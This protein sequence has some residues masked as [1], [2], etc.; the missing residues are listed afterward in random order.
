[1]LGLFYINLVLPSILW[2]AGSNQHYYYKR[3]DGF[4]LDAAIKSDIAGKTPM[5]F[6]PIATGNEQPEIPQT[7]DTGGPGQSEMS[8]FSS[9]NASNMVDLF[10]GDFSYNIPL[11]DVGGYPVNIHYSSGI[12]MDQEASWVGLGWNVNPGTIGRS[13]RG[14][15]DDFNGTDTIT[16]TQ[17]IKE[18][19]TV[20]AKLSAGLELWGL[21]MNVGANFG[22]FH[23]NYQGWG[24][25][26]GINASISAGGKSTGALTGSL[27]L[28]NNSQTGL[29]ISPSLAIRLGGNDAA[30]NGT[31]TVGSNYNSRAGI[32][33][34]QLH[35][36]VRNNI[37]ARAIVEGVVTANGMRVPASVVRQG[38]VSTSAGIAS[39]ISFARPSYLP[40]ITMP[41][42]N[43]SFTFRAQV[44]GELWGV[45]V[46]AAL[47]G[48]GSRQFIR[49]EDRI[50]KLPAYGY[51][52]FS[53]A[54]EQN[55][56]LD[57]NREK[58]IPF[59][60]KTTPHIAIPQ[61]NYDI[62]S[63][64]GEGTGGMFRPYRGDI[65]FIHDHAVSTRTEKINIAT[66][67][68]FGGGVHLGTDFT[69]VNASTT[70]GAW[71]QD[72]ELLKN[73]PF[74]QK[75]STF[76]EVYFRNPGEKAINSSAFYSRLGGDSLIRV[77][78]GG[79]GAGVK[80]LS[81]FTKF[82]QAKPAGDISISSPILKTQRDKRRQVIT[83][84][85][86]DEATRYGLE[87]NIKSYDT[88]RNPVTGCDTAYRIIPRTDAVI[89]KSHHL[90]EMKVLNGDGRIY[91]YGLPV[92]NVEQQDL[93][94]AVNKE[95]NTD[96]LNRGMVSYETGD[97]STTNDKGKDS[98]FNS[99]RTPAYAHSFLLTG[100]LSPDY[101]DIKGDGITDDDLGD[102]VKFN[103][104]QVYGAH[105]GY[106]GWRT[107]VDSGKA[108]YNEGLKTYSRD[109]KGTY[110]YGKKELWYLHSVESK[111]MIALFKTS[112]RTDGY[113]V[114]G[115]SGGFDLTKPLKRLDSIELYTK[116]DLAKNGNNALPVKTVHF[117][118][119]YELCANATGAGTSG[120]LTLKKIWFTYNGNNKGKLNP[121][122]FYYH[123][124]A[125]NSNLP[126]STSNPSY[127]PK[128][129]DRWGNYKD[130]SVN[131][132][133]LNNLD[134]PYTKQDSTQSS[135]F[136]Q[137][138]HLTD[139]KLPSG[140]RMHVG[141]EADDYAY[142]QDKRATQFFPL[143]GFGVTA[144]S[145]P[146]KFLYESENADCYYIFAN[147]TSAVS[148]KKDIY[149]KYLDSLEKIYFKVAVK[150]PADQYGSG[151]EFVP[152][153]AE[154]EDYGTVTGNNTRFWIK[155]KAVDGSSPI[156][157]AAI[158]FLRLN[159]PSKAYPTSEL[160]DNVDIGGVVKM[161][162]SSFSEI[163]NTVEGFDK[164]AK[165][166]SWC[167]ETEAGLSFIRLNSPDY[168][169]YG[170][171]IRVK[172]VEVYD[173]WN[174]MTT[175]SGSSGMKESVYGQ[176]Y[177]YTTTKDVD[178]KKITISS[179]VA[180]YE[181]MIGGEENPFR[182]PVEYIEKVAP[183]APANYM[184]TETPMC[185]SFF[186]S[187]MVGYSKVRVRTINKKAKS[188]N[189]WEE[190]EF[191]TT[192][193][194]PV[195]TET[196][197]LDG[198]SKKRHN[199]KL[200]NLLKVNAQHY[201]TVS[202]GFKIELNDMN[203]KIK[204]QAYFSEKDSIYA[205]HY[206]ETI[207]KTA[208]DRVYNKRLDNKVWTLDS[209]NGRINTDAEIGHE[210]EVMV[211]VR[212]Q[213]SLT[214]SPNSSLNVDIIFPF[215]PP[216]VPVLV[217]PTFYRFAQREEDRFRS[218]AVMK[219]VQR[220]GIA[221][222][223]IVRDKGSVVSTKN[224]VYDG[225]TGNVLV[226]RT[227]NEFKDPV[228]NFN[229][230][231]HWAYSGMG[232]AY[233]NTD[234]VY[235]HKK[236]IDGRIMEKSGSLL[237][238]GKYFESGDE[239]IAVGT[240]R[241]GVAEP[242]NGNDCPLDIFANSSETVRLW[243][244]D[245]AKT[246]ERG[247]GLFFIDSLGRPYSGL[248]DT[249]RIIRSGKRNF[250]DAYIGRISSLTSPIKEVSAGVFKIVI[251]S[252]TKVTSTTATTFRDLWQVENSR[253]QRDTVYRVTRNFTAPTLYPVVTTLYQEKNGIGEIGNTFTVNNSK[254]I[255]SSYDYIPSRGCVRSWN[256]RSK[257]ILRYDLSSIPAG[258]TITSASI[259]FSPRVPKNL[260][261]RKKSGNGNPFC[262]N[263]YGYDWSQADDFR[264][265]TSQ[266]YLRR[267]TATWNAGTSYDL[268]Q[269]TTSSQVSLDHNNS[270]EVDCGNLI[271][272]L[273]SNPNYGLMF[274]VGKNSATSNNY[275][276]NYLNFCS[277]DET[278]VNGP[279]CGSS[280]FEYDMNCNC[281]K[282][283]LYITYSTTVDSTGYICRDNINDTAVNPYRWGILGNWRP[284][285]AYTY[286]SDRQENN[287][288]DP[289]TD[290]RRE[291]TLKTFSPYWQFTDSVLHASIDTLKWVWNSATG[292]YNRRG[293]EIEN[294]DPLGRYNSGLYGYN[295]SLP[296]AVAQNARYREILFDGF[297]DYGYKAENCPVPC[298]TPKEIDFLTGNSTAAIQ[299]S[300][301]HSGRYS[302][303]VNSNSQA[304]FT[305]AVIKDTLL[306]PAVSAPIDSTPVY[307]TRVTG[308]GT[309]LSG[310]Y[311]CVYGPGSSI[312]RTEGPINFRYN[313]PALTLPACDDRRNE[314]YA[315]KAE[316][317]GKIQPVFT[318]KYTFYI[319]SS[320]SG[321]GLK[322]NNQVLIQPT[323]YPGNRT[324]ITIQLEAGKLYDISILFPSFTRTAGNIELSWSSASNQV[325][326]I[327]PKENLYPPTITT[328]DTAGSLTRN[329]I[330]YCVALSNVKPENIL[331][332]VFSPIQS[333]KIVASVW[334]NTNTTDCSNPGTT[335]VPEGQAI[336]SFNVGSPGT[337]VTLQKTGIAI[338]G[339][340]RYE[341]FIDVPSTATQIY[342][343]LKSATAQRTYFDDLRVHPYNSNMKS[344]AYDPVSLRLMAE[345][346]ENNYAS[347]YEY[348]DD[349]TLIRV[350]KETE[351]GIK[352]I[353]ESRSALFKEEE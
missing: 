119:S 112:S 240:R 132:G 227:N 118:Y 64:S 352:T 22:V 149:T 259:S 210:V 350:K 66:D 255:I 254:N 115:K 32:S 117:E 139:I 70:T 336:I 120:K 208:P 284:D 14:L 189:G 291:G 6:K 76:Q 1:M 237:D 278:N 183:M 252:N 223:V 166:R 288:S 232:M 285:R 146:Q 182:T 37:S 290:I 96:D 159:L 236:I 213:R 271:Q 126:T 35:T 165:S 316:W 155:L 164:A 324:S 95:E 24:I 104:S 134:Y 152:V 38:S 270:E 36:E 203:G 333:T 178:G 8:S 311:S 199:P 162:G 251:D 318:D 174:K 5:G 309:G 99:D 57:F 11:M 326:Q 243:A 253:Y 111:A 71:Q 158:Q 106:Y 4:H 194:F 75:D 129:Y 116:A 78:L 267:I 198:D 265:G 79:S 131:P 226:T 197:P 298:P 12:S 266:V 299:D 33:G 345:L 7:E 58:D 228:Y 273:V 43:S 217:A 286:Y 128:T 56:L 97:D 93:T 67:L 260:F 51:L 92:Y 17:N 107:P 108:N 50:Q 214:S 3:N 2:A 231:A 342:I 256:L 125:G 45:N 264:L 281:Y 10:T 293:F 317:S 156:A 287:A 289:A 29:D 73:I 344:F 206:S 123:P 39:Y 46:N 321:A 235:S 124:D 330:R 218:I 320:R 244:I 234:A 262:P 301:S 34:L 246:K 114:R 138:W 167:K 153:Y 127:N 200:K 110:M 346:D 215:L 193:D 143:A 169:K 81:S 220:Y 151:Y 250:T 30:M 91:V 207:Y 47:E 238:A 87:K 88:S 331:K 15:P 28:S 297:E 348:D 184:Y 80:A 94:F 325:K 145:T 133:G 201:L 339:W 282:P 86:G 329:I 351:R 338:E 211:D 150:M 9:V 229:Y 83:Y 144:Q 157:K 304:V 54:T 305:A 248:V 175:R 275:E 225:E 65:G 247:H 257:T 84:L 61:Y 314:L 154:I 18:N 109:D 105:N 315:W 180:S 241:T 137:V 179:G 276:T 239:I 102:G 192:K 349:G 263:T 44:G 191:Y 212:Q 292:M 224:L 294:Y 16:R 332:P 160:G 268:F 19:K 205:L 249:M 68:G 122:Q 49:P 69:D 177:T 258:S 319:N 89:R 181:P 101:V 176:E 148:N 172:R 295:E 25:E 202:Q 100:L 59:N 328:S 303:T 313:N 230:P 216:F 233:K 23:N 272:S 323:V 343:T 13:M 135:A 335:A 41:L 42:T 322:I 186:P 21:P 188:A 261:P 340:Q 121:Y 307:E 63:I 141:F 40:T 310:V 196:T 142:V 187:P 283:Q 279:N 113:S 209:A 74:S 341:S 103:Y 312:T 168:K 55:A 26:H 52:N 85:N 269:T 27:A 308:K 130:P 60:H 140:G 353:K 173:N 31:V 204:S 334:I 20:G 337:S 171:G 302:L 72:N 62:Y 170:G 274:Q 48:Y 136:A 190:T 77:K 82:S 90:S 185:E 300:I 242:P 195:R 347:F 306:V 327:V 280:K 245:A 219:V 147:V 53:K 98:Y 221:D 163:K 222:S 277:G 296:V 161:M